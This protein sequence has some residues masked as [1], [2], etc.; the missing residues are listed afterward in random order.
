MDF[1]DVAG[2]L[3]ERSNAMQS[4]WSY[5]IAVS[6]ALL[7]FFGTSRRSIPLTILLTVA[8]IGIAAANLGGMKNVAQQRV[9]LRAL[10]MQA[11][12][13]NA[14]KVFKVP[15][16]SEAVVAAYLDVPPPPPV[17][18][19]IAT[20]LCCDVVIIAAIWVL[21]LWPSTASATSIWFLG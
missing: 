14:D 5:Y 21:R 20:H 19:V 18:G 10:L 2:H 4:F 1:K 15:L 6:G 12:T 3:F 9:A 8:F 13:E 7:A 17:N 11:R 16:P